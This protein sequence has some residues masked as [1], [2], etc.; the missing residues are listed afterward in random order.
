MSDPKTLHY[1]PNLVKVDEHPAWIQFDFFERRKPAGDDA[2]I[3]TDIIQLYMPEQA[4]QP[5]TVS[6]GQENFGFIGNAI[7]NTASAA[8][9]G[10]GLAGATDALMGSVDG[11]VD[12]AL[13]QFLST[14]GS[15]LASMLGGNVS[16]EGLLGSVAGK[17][18]NPYL[19]AVFRGVDFRS[20]A[21]T[22]KFYPF[23]LSDCDVINDIIKTFRANALPEYQ[24]GDTFLGY[25]REAQISYKW[26]GKDNQWL[27][28]FKRAVCTAID[29]DYTGQGM[30][31]VM[32]NGFPS[33]ITV[34]TKWTE[35]EIVTRKDIAGGF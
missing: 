4:S 3:K 19:T 22:F 8:F 35:L 20:F 16:A 9:N 31:S 10:G 7:R 14:A 6:W 24:E 25:P 2:Q 30:F 11:S 27:H 1:P 13:T 33:E 12:R 17:I 23:Q 28:K 5:S 18:P 26:K 15:S 32:R 34:S 29:V 21:F